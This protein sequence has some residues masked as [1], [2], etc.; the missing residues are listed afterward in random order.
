[1]NYN[2]DYYQGKTAVVTGAASGIGLALVEELLLC[3]A[4]K[5]VMADI[6][7]GNLTKHEAR[8]KVQYG[9]RVKGLLCDVTKEENVKRL[10]GESAAFFDGRFDLLINNAGAGFVSVFGETTNEQWKL[11]FDLNFY[12]A[13]Y[14]MREVLP[15]M[16]EQGSGQ[17]INIISGIAFIPFP[18]Q[19]LYSA[20]K[21]ALNGL[22]LALRYEYGDDNIKI[23]SA[24]PGTT[25][26]AIWG[27]TPV[28][29]TAQSPQESASH[30]LK[31]AAQNYR[32]IFGDDIDL[33]FAKVCFD[34]EKQERMDEL[35]FNVS[36][37]RRKG[38]SGIK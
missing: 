4:S 34:H 22:S 1:M 6:N 36:R 24:T 28:P 16:C 10:I 35:G 19:T 9:D 30:I 23:S 17:I 12:A 13:L 21:A 5:V 7:V 26:T 37:A 2:Q 8:L 32:L 3:D 15:I 20:T 29:E 25:N 18:Y 11:A 27:D 31:G 14:G 33:K 38:E